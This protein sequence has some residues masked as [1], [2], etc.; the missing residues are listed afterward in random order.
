MWFRSPLRNVWSARCGPPFLSIAA[1]ESC[2]T[3]PPNRL[4]ICHLGVRGAC[5]EGSGGLLGDSWGVLGVLWRVL[6]PLGRVLG[7]SWGVLGR[8]WGRLRVVL[9]GLG[10]LRGPLDA[11]GRVLGRLGGRLGRSLKIRIFLRGNAHFRGSGASRGRRGSVPEGSRRRLGA[12]RGRLGAS[13]RRPGGLS[14][15]SEP[16]PSCFARFCGPGQASGSA[17]TPFSEAFGPLDPEAP[18]SNLE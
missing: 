17:E 3:D 4:K 14:G 5:P 9:G 16:K 8:L 2:Q 18:R 15:P 11:S 13:W 10:G 1:P 12:S 6:G 7:P